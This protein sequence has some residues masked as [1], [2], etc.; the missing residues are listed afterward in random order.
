MTSESRVTVIE[1]VGGPCDG[2]RVRE[3]VTIDGGT[4]VM[5]RTWLCRPAETRGHP[6]EYWP[7]RLVDG[8]Y[9]WSANEST[10]GKRST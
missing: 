4:W 10:E 7:Y 1:V 2:Q 5:E 9:V 6:R 8:R 3:L